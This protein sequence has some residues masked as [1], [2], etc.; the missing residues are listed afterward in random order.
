[1][2]SAWWCHAVADDHAHVRAALL[3]GIDAIL[4][5]FNHARCQIHPDDNGALG[6][7]EQPCNRGQLLPR[8]AARHQSPSPIAC[9]QRLELCCEGREG[10]LSPRRKARDEQLVV[11]RRCTRPAL[12]QHLRCRQRHRVG[13]RRRRRGAASQARPAQ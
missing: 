5:D 2:W 1:M 10:I 6:S 4:C 9:W 7:T 11:A 13:P 8:A 3:V 12:G